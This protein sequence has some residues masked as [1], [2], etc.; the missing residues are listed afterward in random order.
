MIMTNT[1]KQSLLLPQ[2]S[3]QKILGSTANLSK[4]IYTDQM[5][6]IPTIAVAGAARYRSPFAARIPDQWEG[7]PLNDRAHY[8]ASPV[9]KHS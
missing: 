3:N 6:S 4:Q 1:A 9:V 5:S 7:S 2:L 8:N